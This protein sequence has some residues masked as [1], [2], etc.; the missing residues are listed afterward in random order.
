MTKRPNAPDDIDSLLAEQRELREQALAIR[1]KT[2]EIQEKLQGPP[3]TFR[4]STYFHRSVHDALLK[5]AHDE[6]KTVTA[7]LAEGIDHVLTS[8]KY[9]TA[10]ELREKARAANRERVA[11]LA[12]RAGL[13]PAGEARREMLEAARKKV[14]ESARRYRTAP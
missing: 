12:R 3:A 7:L 13:P 1:R 14:A 5:I 2:K 8:R 10:A 6:R 11:E 4:T 9:P